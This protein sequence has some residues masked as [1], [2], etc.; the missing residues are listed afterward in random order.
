MMKEKC[1]YVDNLNKL[2]IASTHT[3]AADGQKP[4]LL[5]V[6][7]GTSYKETRKLTIDAI[8]AALA[9]AYPEYE[10]RRAFTS[11][12]VINILEKR[13][14]YKIDN[15]ADAME[16]LIADGVK[17]VLVQSTHVIPG[18]EYNDMLKELSA[19]ADKFKS[20]QIGTALLTSD[21]DYDTL[22][23][24]LKK[25]TAKYNAEDTAIVFM[26]HG[27]RH[28]AN[29]TY[30]E[31]ERRLHAAGLANYFIG[32][33]EGTPLV[34]EVLAK[35]NAGQYSKVVLLPLMIVAGDH[36]SNDMAGDEE[37]SWKDIF[38]KA[39]YE[40]ECILTGL[41][42]YEGIRQMFIAHADEAMK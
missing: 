15:V 11:Q 7:F 20:L 6:S 28:E 18:F 12:M 23:T 9:E 39:G 3:A 29:E 37:G 30:I 34:D 38:T 17:E 36:A 41:G 26:G 2:E 42:Q 35:V 14:G 22:V 4:V 19:Y 5:A 32:T 40:V 33:A 31:I 25:E 13:D 21:Q 8:E 10:V 27:S 24:V 1:G 16:R